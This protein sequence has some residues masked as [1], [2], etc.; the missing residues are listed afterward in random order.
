[1][2]PMFI[3][4]GP[5]IWLNPMSW[6]IILEKEIAR[7]IVPSITWSQNKFDLY[8]SSL[9]HTQYLYSIFF[10]ILLDMYIVSSV[11]FDIW[12]KFE[13]IISTFL[14]Q[15]MVTKIAKHTNQGKH[16]HIS[17]KWWELVS[18]TQ[19]KKTNV[20]NTRVWNN[21]VSHKCTCTLCAV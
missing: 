2:E 1:M 21:F 6:W 11:S 13:L 10:I 9:L 12:I 16:R 19:M 3:L 7:S 14:Y 20:Y 15:Y 8:I 5:L 18:E 17:K 4:F